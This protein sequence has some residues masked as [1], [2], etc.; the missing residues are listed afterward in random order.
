MCNL[1][2]KFRKARNV[3]QSEYLA[4]AHRDDVPY[5]TGKV[6]LYGSQKEADSLDLRR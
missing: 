6:P 4:V 5:E 1:C 3:A 2:S